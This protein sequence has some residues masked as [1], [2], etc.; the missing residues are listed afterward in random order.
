[1]HDKRL[2][3]V[4]GHYGSG[5]TE[6]AVN[7]A[8]K[9]KEIYENVSI[10]DLDIVNPYFRSREKRK[11]FEEI[12]IKLSDSS[13]RNT[14]IDLPA[15]PAE[16]MGVIANPNIKSILD[17]GGDP[18]G[19]RVLARYAEQIKNVEYDM[20]YVIN[21][22]R[23]DTSTVEGVL[24]YMKL[25]ETTSRLKIT[26][27]VNNTHMLKATTVEDVEFGHELT[28]KVSWET[29]IPIRYEAVIKETA[30]KIKNQ[31]IIEK[32]FPINLYMREEWMS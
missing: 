9:M 1:M 20:F 29:D 10:A 14:A 4:I 5:K 17:V 18:V 3:I 19:A 21:G 32:L 16:M 24:K 7:Y 30:D 22:N 27:L 13:I 23:P 28:K 6:F 12:G 26:G 2:V 11:F 15:L 31:D 25:I 8:V